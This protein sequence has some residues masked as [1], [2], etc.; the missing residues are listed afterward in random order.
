MERSISP[1]QG[2]RSRTRSACKGSNIDLTAREGLQETGY[3]RHRFRGLEPRRNRC[4]GRRGIIGDR[5]WYSPT[6]PASTRLMIGDAN[7]IPSVGRM[8]LSIL[9]YDTFSSWS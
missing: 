8:N 5:W 2:V 9:A 3:H 1:Q 6:T 7:Q 4:T